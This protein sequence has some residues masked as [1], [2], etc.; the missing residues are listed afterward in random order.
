[1]GSKRRRRRI[2]G[3]MPRLGRG[4]AATSRWLLKYPQPFVFVGGVGFIVWA[5]WG[6]AQQADAFRV[7]QVQ[8]PLQSSLKVR[9]SVIGE[10]LWSFDIQRLADDLKRQQP[11]LKEVR[12]IRQLPN[13][14]RIQAIE[15]RTVAQVRLDRWYAVDEDGFILPQGDAE[16][17]EG[18]IRIS[19]VDRGPA[20]T[21]G[22]ESTDEQLL[23]A[24][25]VLQILRH[26]SFT[27]ARRFTEI[28]VSD[29]AHLRFILDD[30]EIRCGSETELPTH[31]IRLKATLKEISRHQLAVRYIDV[32]FEKPVI[33]PQTS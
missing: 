22:K 11:W 16:P 23:L 20:L 10:N 26:Q 33:G 4:L 2:P 24:L 25:R 17:A 1:M 27:L 21:I 29:P 32:S 31:L 15:R 6:Y 9:D 28:N 13:T 19:G 8:L 18:L 30:V 14:I 12:V 5:L 3:I 7:E